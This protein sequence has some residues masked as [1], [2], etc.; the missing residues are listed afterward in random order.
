M[1]LLGVVLGFSAIA[2]APF[3]P[4]NPHNVALGRP[5]TLTP[6]PNYDHP[7]PGIDNQ[8]GDDVDLTDGCFVQAS[9]AS[10][11]SVTWG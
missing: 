11:A 9:H 4:P 6:A 5:Y 2:A 10:E 3:C 1:A 7:D 8:G